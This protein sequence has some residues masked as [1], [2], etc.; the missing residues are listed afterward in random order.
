MRGLRGAAAAAFCWRR[1]AS[2]V[3]GGGAPSERARSFRLCVDGPQLCVRLAC[4]PPLCLLTPFC[5]ERQSEFHV[6]KQPQHGAISVSAACL[7]KLR[8]R[9]A[10]RQR[11]RALLL[12]VDASAAGLAGGSPATADPAR[13]SSP[14]SEVSARSAP[15]DDCVWPGRARRGAART[16]AR[17]QGVRLGGRARFGRL[18]QRG[19]RRGRR[20]T[21][22]VFLYERARP[23][24]CWCVQAPSAHDGLHRRQASARQTRDRGRRPVQGR[25][26]VDRERLLEPARTASRS[27]APR[28]VARH[29]EA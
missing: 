8:E 17:H 10:R 23:K 26:A 15:L 19:R 1:F 11:R 20:A 3:R 14:H 2:S 24:A 13:P 4:G 7:P 27:G 25:V 16:R 22:L 18:P 12:G 6:R 28:R 5:G 29:D 21:A 9:R